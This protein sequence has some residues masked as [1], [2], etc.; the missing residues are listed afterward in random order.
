MLA[1][2]KLLLIF[3]EQ[4]VTYTPVELNTALSIMHP[5]LVV[6]FQLGLDWK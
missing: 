4:L 6:S 5:L 2:N 3:G 1:V